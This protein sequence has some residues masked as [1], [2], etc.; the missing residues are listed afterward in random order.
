M[1]SMYMYH[2]TN[3][4]MTIKMKLSF[5]SIFDTFCLRIELFRMK[6][7][8]INRQKL[9]TVIRKSFRIGTVWQNQ[10]FFNEI[11]NTIEIHPMAT[12]KKKTQ[13][14][15]FRLM[16][17]QHVTSKVFQMISDKTWLY[18]HFNAHQ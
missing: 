7:I 10:L 11:P 3:L 4:V 17:F 1:G 16:K 9:T 12:F 8:I 5:I 6:K 18:Q 15:L 2:E 13:V 14:F